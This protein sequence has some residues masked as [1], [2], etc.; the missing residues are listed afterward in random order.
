MPLTLADVLRVSGASAEVEAKLRAF[1]AERVEFYLREVRGQA[2]DVVKAVMAPGFEDLSDTIARAEALTAVRG[3]ADFVAVSAAF[4][5]MK[6]IL[7]QA[8]AKGEVF[9]GTSG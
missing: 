3:G 7:E 6:N 4:K 1:F 8:E 5:R 9:G 2:Y